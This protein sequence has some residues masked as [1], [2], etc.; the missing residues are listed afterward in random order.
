[1]ALRLY[2]ITVHD[3]HG[4][5]KPAD[6]AELLG[7]RELAA[8]VGPGEYQAGTPSGECIEK[9]RQVVDSV[10]AT[11]PI[12]PAPVGTVFRSREILTRWLELHYVTLHDALNFV[13]DREVAR[14]HI[15]HRGGRPSDHEA[16]ADVAAAAAESFRILRRLAVTSLALDTEHLTGIVLSSSFLVEKELW[17]DFTGAVEAQ[18]ARNPTLAFE[19]SGP[20]PPYD[21]VRMQ[22]GQ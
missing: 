5:V 21:F 3:G 4:E 15:G 1:M 9:H 10:F 11:A 6:G 18:R 22:F 17:H 2:G 12:L 7:V 14:V 20:W 8:V 16:G 19:L 13:E